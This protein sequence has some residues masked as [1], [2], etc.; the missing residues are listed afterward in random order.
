[1]GWET[2]ERKAIDGGSTTES[3]HCADEHLTWQVQQEA[4]AARGGLGLQDECKSP[5][6]PAA[7]TLV[8]LPHHKG[9]PVNIFTPLPMAVPSQLSFTAN[10][11]Y[12]LIGSK[13]Y[14][15]FFHLIR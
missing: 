13:T 3:R 10:L 9:T 8:P 2:A 5:S 1:M 11:F 12:I 6:Y 14:L 15:L 7:P 4:A